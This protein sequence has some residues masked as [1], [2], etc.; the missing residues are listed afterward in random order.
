MALHA[1]TLAWRNLIRHKSFTIINVL[2]LSIGITCCL[3]IIV[4][5]QYETSFDAYHHQAAQTY[6]VVE[7]FKNPEGTLHWNTTA[8]PLA[9]ALRNDF[10]EIPLVTQAAGPLHRLFK[11]EDAQGNVSRYEEDRVM[12]VDP[13]YPKVFDIT[14]L[15]GNPETALLQPNAAVLTETVARKFFGDAMK[16]NESVLGKHILLENKDELT[17]TGL[18]A[19]APMNSGLRYSMLIPYEFFKVNNPYFSGN[20]SGNYQGTTFVTL[21]RGQSPA[22]LEA[23][24]ATWKKKYLKPED[25]KRISYA[26]QPLA[27]A[28]NDEVYGAGPQSYTMP[29]KFIYAATGIAFFILLIACVNFINLATA[30]AANRAKEVGIRKVLG[31]SRFGLVKQFLR[32]H[33]LLIVLSLLV[34]LALTQLVLRYLNTALAIIDLKLALDSRVLLWALGI[35]VTVMLLACFY[36]ALVMSALRPIEALKSKFSGREG[37]GLSLRRTLIVFQFAIVQLFII[38]TIVAATQMDYF[39]QKDL[40]FSKDAVLITYIH[41]GK[42]REVFRQR[43]LS[44]PAVVD[45]TFSSSSPMAS[46]D[47]R[48]GTSYRLPAQPVEEGQEAEMKGADVNYLSF[49]N[50]Q[51]LAGRNFTTVEENLKEFIVNETL[52]KGLGWTPEDAVGRRLTINEGEGT[53]VGVVKDFHNESLQ[54]EITPCLLMNWESFLEFTSIKLADK[55]KLTETLPFVERTWKTTYPEGIYGYEFL[56]DALARK[57]ALQQIVF[58]GFTSFAL[59][60]ICIGCLGLYGLLS[61]IAIRK[62]KEVGIRKVLG[63]SVRQIVTLFS[64]EF[65][66]LLLV[67]FAVAAPL[68]AWLMEHWLRDFAYRISLSWWMFALGAVVTLVIML[69]TIGYKSVRAG[70]ANPVDAL[71][72][73]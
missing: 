16:D 31:S 44:N 39:R 11:I 53:V 2:G 9:E 65:I 58:Q 18:V 66:V 4:F 23:R 29:Q 3:S 68:A 5:V 61:F 67:A 35:G 70:M 50:L 1:F 71:R 20:W 46:Y 59:L 52:L 43:L 17:V 21:Q 38:A 51:L 69:L 57:Y 62:T 60:T 34:S 27:E 25:D 49:Y 56:D 54:E 40:G 10:Q 22:D 32:E 33:S 64:R 47:Y 73:E 28:H 42:D 24:I 15:A 14:W 12:M 8:Y 19:D 48:Y 7:D 6:R 36:P 13:F 45:V 72:S 37:R 63:A 26:L 41:N 55:A 30:L